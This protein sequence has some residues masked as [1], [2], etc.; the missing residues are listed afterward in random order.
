MQT[1]QVQFLSRELG[2]RFKPSLTAIS[3]KP[4]PQIWTPGPQPS[5]ADFPE[6]EFGGPASQSL[7]PLKLGV[8]LSP[9]KLLPTI[10]KGSLAPCGSGPRSYRVTKRVFEQGSGLG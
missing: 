3:L 6:E 7:H 8:A 10:S 9:G 5:P 1:A 2:S 4:F